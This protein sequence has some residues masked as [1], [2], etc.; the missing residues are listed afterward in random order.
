MKTGLFVVL[1]SQKWKDRTAGLVFSSL[2]PVQL[3][4]FSSLETGPLNTNDIPAGPLLGSYQGAEALEHLWDVVP[5]QTG[6]PA[7]DIQDIR[8]LCRGEELEKRDWLSI[9]IML[10]DS[11]I[12]EHLCCTDLF[13]FETPCRVSSYR[14]WK[15]NHQH[16]HQSSPPSWL[17]PHYKVTNPHQHISS[18]EID[19]TL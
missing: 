8:V 19:P 13:F 9:R 14:P 3:R 4:S 6:L 2:G 5:D 16:W 18:L 1:R 11:C 10:K 7:R 17:W 15:N 12:C